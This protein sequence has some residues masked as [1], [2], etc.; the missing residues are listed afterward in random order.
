MKHLS[1]IIISMLLVIAGCDTT[2]T[3]GSGSGS[4]RILPNVT[5]GAGEVLVVIDKFVWD[6]QTGESLKDILEEE[7]PALPQSEPLFGVTQI[8]SASFDNVYR[9]HRSVVLLIRPGKN[10]PSGTGEM[11]G[12]NHRS[13]FRWKLPAARN[14]TS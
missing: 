6:G 9:Y 14:S 13:L 4:G 1:F 10:Q 2:I 12:P 8:T 7:F 5:G 11:S 3:P